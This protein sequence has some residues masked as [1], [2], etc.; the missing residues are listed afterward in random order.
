MQAKAPDDESLPSWRG[1]R[2][3]RSMSLEVM[4]CFTT[5]AMTGKFQMAAAFFQVNRTLT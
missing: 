2:P 1:R 5:F 3:W 4:D